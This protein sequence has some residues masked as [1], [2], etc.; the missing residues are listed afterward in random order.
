M[1][2]TSKVLADLARAKA[3]FQQRSLIAL[4]TEQPAKSKPD[5]ERDKEGE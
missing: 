3:L 1:A 5:Q 4:L 2:D